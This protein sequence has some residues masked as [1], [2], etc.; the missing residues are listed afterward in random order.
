MVLEQPEEIPAV[1]RKGKVMSMGAYL[2]LEDGSVYAGQARGAFRETI[3]EIV[4]NT[5]MAG[6]VEALTDP[7]CAGLGIVMTYPIVGNYGVCRE[8][9]ESERLRPAAFL[10][11]ELCNSHSNFRSGGSLEELLREYEIPCLSDLDTRSIVK[12]IREKGAMRGLLTEDITNKE[13]CLEAIASYR[14]HR[15]VESVSVGEIVTHGTENTGP[16]IALLDLGTKYGIAKALLSRGCSV[17]QYPYNTPAAQILAGGHDGL[18]L[19]SGP[20]DPRDCPEI[21]EEVKALY[22]ACLP[23][24]GIGL[25]H[26]LLALAAGCTVERMNCGHRGSYPVKSL[27]EDR[28]YFADQNHGYVVTL[29]S[30]P[31]QVSIN[32]INVNDGTVEGLVYAGKPMFSLQF[33]PEASPGPEDTGFLFGR[34]L[35]MIAHG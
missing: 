33:H 16:S 20:G 15:P 35:D 29:E 17:T 12:K 3:C 1:H 30:L 8:D 24:V 5:A 2:L 25:G 28:T 26:Q 21:V 10:V 7:S 4:F 6:Y 32:W 34:Y 9:F 13:R 18:L 27:E 23:T 11:H 19:S 14:Q 22:A 31:E